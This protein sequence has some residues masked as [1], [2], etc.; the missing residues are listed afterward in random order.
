MKN[1][2]SCKFDCIGIEDRF[3]ETG[4]YDELLA[5]YG[6]SAENIANKAKALIK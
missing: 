1:G 6:I 4:P 5:K 2:V 3:T